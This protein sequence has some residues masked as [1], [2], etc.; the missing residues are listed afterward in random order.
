MISIREIANRELLDLVPYEPGK[1]VDDVAREIGL[2]PASVIKLASNENPLGPS[3]LAIAAMRAEVDRVHFYPDGGGFHLR[4]AIAEKFGLAREN[5][6][7]GNGSNE[8]IE[9]L[10]HTFTRPGIHEI[11]TARHA[12]AVYTLMAQLFG[13]RAI[14]VDDVDFTPD[15]EAM[16]RAITPQTRL[17]FLAS[18]N[19]PT[20]TRVTNEALDAFL[21]DLPS[22]VVAVLD[23]A[24]YE[25]IDYPPDTIGYVKRDA[26]VVLM[27]TFSKIQ[28]LAG[29]RIGYG[30]AP[31]EI[32]DLLQRA[33]QPFNANSL[34]QAGAIAGLN[35]TE[36]Q[37]RTKEITDEGRALVERTFAGM[38]LSYVPS[39]AN[40]VMVNVGDGGEVFKRLMKKGII[41]RSMVSYHLPAYI[42]VSIGTPEQNQRFLT[43]LPQALHGLVEFKEYKL[44]PDHPKALFAPIPPESLM[45]KAPLP[46]D[47]DNV[48]RR[49][50]TVAGSD[51][52]PPAHP[53]SPPDPGPDVAPERVPESD[54]TP[55]PEREPEETG[56]RAGIPT[57]YHARSVYRHFRSV[58]PSMTF[59]TV[60][61]LGPGLI[62]GSLALALAERQLAERLM[63]YARSPHAL[64]EIRTAGVEAELHGNPSE[65]VSEAD[66][67]ILCVPIEA[68]ADLVHQIRG[69]LNPNTL[70]TDVGSVKGSVVRDLEPL[71][72]GR[73]LWIGSH[74]MAGSEQTGFAAARPDLFEGA[75]VIITPTRRTEPEAER[76]GAQFWEALGGRVTTLSPDDHDEAVAL[77]SHVPH[78]VASALTYWSSPSLQQREN[79]GAPDAQKLA[80]GGFRDITRIAS[81]SPELWAEI[82]LANS[83][84]VVTALRSLGRVL[85]KF[86]ALI[87][88]G[89]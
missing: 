2:D 50:A 6:V 76:R 30:L 38:G 74:P 22:H 48:L 78:V 14:I 24:Y 69:D 34:A 9:L 32:A 10:F 5:V 35:D 27:R 66:V 12:F 28:G 40:F 21:R 80:G 77:I 31:A 79:P 25:F 36:H 44:L 16:R 68:M 72:A 20:G 26:H 86:A 81:G 75:S 61:I 58:G 73:A 3:P 42:R 8:I 65:A 49:A 13:V 47:T 11:V 54:P 7:L 57:R 88:D 37:R 45:E 63:I 17:V 82:L 19:N 1:P 84:T 85:E 15:L 71:L 67:V 52:H 60:A 62:G 23:E 56:P 87:E 43:E 55:N 18:P 83:S 70:V 39:S 29:L 33:R 53:I 59:G 51:P 4:N 46:L 41:V 64:D 89:D